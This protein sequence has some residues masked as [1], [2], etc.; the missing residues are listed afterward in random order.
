MMQKGVQKSQA[1][2][3]DLTAEVRTKESDKCHGR[4]LFGLRLPQKQAGA[5]ASIWLRHI[6]GYSEH[7]LLQES[8]TVLHSIRACLQI[9]GLKASTRCMFLWTSLTNHPH[10]SLQ[11]CSMVVLRATIWR[12]VCRLTILLEVSQSGSVGRKMRL[13]VSMLFS[14]LG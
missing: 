8:N 13:S 5:L 4:A 14:S 7:Y 3:A 6:H 2:A 9:C 11:A 12:H 10:V 1:S